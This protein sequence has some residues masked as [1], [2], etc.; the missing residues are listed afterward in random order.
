MKKIIF[1]A[2]YLIYSSCYAQSAYE[3]SL[4]EEKAQLVFDLNVESKELISFINNSRIL[5]QSDKETL[6][7]QV[8]A[9]N[10]PMLDALNSYGLL[11]SSGKS[12]NTNEVEVYNDYFDRL[13]GSAYKMNGILYHTIDSANPIRI[14]NELSCKTNCK[15]QISEFIVDEF[16]KNIYTEEDSFK[17]SLDKLLPYIEADND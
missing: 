4:Y 15:K 5:T 16:S 3:V 11:I 10:E 7:K 1:L 6:V 9:V 13:L 17:T 12:E 14:K 2:L 8:E